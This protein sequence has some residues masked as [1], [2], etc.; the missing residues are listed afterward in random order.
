MSSSIHTRSS[1]F[2]NTKRIYVEGERS[3]VRVPFREI[4]QHVTKSFNGA[5][6]VNEPVRVYETSGPWGDPG[7][8][9]DVRDGLLPLR[10]A[11]IRERLDVEEY[12]GRVVEPVDD[13]YRSAEEAAYVR[14]KA[15]GKLAE[16]PGLRRQP[17]R[18]QAGRAVTQMHY[19]KR[20]IITPEME[21]IAIRENL[22]RQAAFD[23]VHKVVRSFQPTSITRRA[24][25]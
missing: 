17:L 21:F 6:E 16:F 23:A 19:A 15:R 3:G 9:G 4:E 18:A 7:F 13:G 10:L 22:G 11:W 2:P 12:E 5:V 25:R 14:E 24:S 20:G 1:R 8:T